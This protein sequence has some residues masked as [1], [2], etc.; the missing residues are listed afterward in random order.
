MENA[1]K[2]ARRIVSSNLITGSDADDYIQTHGRACLRCKS[3]NLKSGPLLHGAISEKH[4]S[5]LNPTRVVLCGDCG[6][7]WS[8]LYTLSGVTTDILG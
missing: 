1:R 4:R 8:E 6:E 2:T 3:R 7:A 5:H